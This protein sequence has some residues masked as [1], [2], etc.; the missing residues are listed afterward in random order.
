M[1]II[2]KAKII[3]AGKLQH[4]KEEKNILSFGKHPFLV[5]L[6]YCFHTETKIYFVM[7][8]I[9]GGDLFSH[10]RKIGSFSEE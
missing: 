5:S 4:T 7:D 3:E 1:K 8:Y 9:E 2:K 10:L 6:H